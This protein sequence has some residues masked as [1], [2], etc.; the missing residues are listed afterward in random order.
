[1]LGKVHDICVLKIKRPFSLVI[2]CCAAKNYGV[3]TGKYFGAKHPFSKNE[4]R[5]RQDALASVEG[6]VSGGSRG[7]VCYQFRIIRH[8]SGHNFV[9]YNQDRSRR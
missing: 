5:N 3:Y 4:V 8:F 7:T 6:D 2:L 9:L 1:M